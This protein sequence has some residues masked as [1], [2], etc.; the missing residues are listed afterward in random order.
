MNK[1]V[2]AGETLSIITLFKTTF[3]LG[4]S[5]NGSQNFGHC[6]VSSCLHCY[7][8]GNPSQSQ[9]LVPFNP[10]HGGKLYI[11]ISKIPTFGRFWKFVTKK[12]KKAQ[13]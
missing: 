6:S 10:H 4:S 12:P 7:H 13:K 1:S 5:G 8:Q 2:S 11:L 9:A 3:N